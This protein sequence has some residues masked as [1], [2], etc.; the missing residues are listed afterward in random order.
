M[1]NLWKVLWF[2]AWDDIPKTRENLLLV[3]H[4]VARAWELSLEDDLPALPG[5]AEVAAMFD[6]TVRARSNPSFA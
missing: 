2:H 1:A 5:E 3:Q 6:H 4:I